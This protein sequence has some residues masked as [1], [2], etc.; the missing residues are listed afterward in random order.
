MKAIVVREDRSLDWTEVPEP[1]CGPQEVILAIQAS[2]VNR[3]DLLQRR[4]L[5]PPPPGAPEWMGLEA[6]GTIE[7]IGDGVR[8]RGTWQ[9]GDAA[10]ALLAGGGYAER[11]AV[12]ESL[13]LPVPRGLEVISAASIPEVFATAYLNLILEGGLQAGERVLIHAGASGVGTA[14]IQ[15]ARWRGADV[16][17]TV[18][19]EAKAAAA[20][21]LGA[22]HVIEYKRE[23]VTTAFHPMAGGGTG[24][25]PDEPGSAAARGI[26]VVLD[27]LGGESVGAHLPLL[28]PGGRWILI[29]LMNGPTTSLDLR[30]FLARRL[31]LVGSTLRSRPLAEKGALLEAMRRDLWPQFVSGA[32]R[33]VIH[34][35]L[36]I[37]QAEQAHELVRRNESIGKVVL[38]IDRG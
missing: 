16:V 31:R 29:G 34:R 20:R 26:D 5:Y 1:R 22:G 38:T 11:V 3:A 25:Q 2:A 30:P 24:S 9:P 7:A 12:H 21:A 23:D 4:G 35:V 13:L 14:A 33:P 15:V 6:S 10:C 37:T 36:P 17:V 8:A 28:N 32:I 19:S 27:C 18:G